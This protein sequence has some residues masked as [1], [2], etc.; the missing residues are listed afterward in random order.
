MKQILVAVFRDEKA[1]FAGWQALTG[2]PA[3]SS[4][5]PDASAVLTMEP[6]AQLRLR[7]ESRP[8]SRATLGGL[9]IGGALGSLGG[10]LV[11]IAGAWVGMLAGLLCDVFSSEFDSDL[12]EEVGAVLHPGE[13]S[14]IAR[15]DGGDADRA[16]ARLALSGGRVVRR[17]A[18]ALAAAGTV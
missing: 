1:A 4:T 6:D 15:L 14:V 12:L 10:P 9:V 3:N 16:E 2:S 13:S 11:A 18:Q 7:A 8:E 5:K 17:G